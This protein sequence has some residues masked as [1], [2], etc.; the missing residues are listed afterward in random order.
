MTNVKLPHTGWDYIVL[1]LDW[2]TKKIDVMG[3]LV[4]P[5]PMTGWTR[6]M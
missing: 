4:D 1:V 6:L 2:N 3:L 5:K